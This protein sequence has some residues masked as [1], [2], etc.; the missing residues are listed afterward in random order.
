MNLLEAATRI[1][2]NLGSPDAPTVGVIQYYLRHNI[3][4][5]NNLINTGFSIEPVDGTIEP[6]LDEDAFGVYQCLYLIYYYG[7]KARENL[8]A[9]AID[10][11][12]EVAENGAVVRLT[13]RNSI[14]LSYIQLKKQEEEQLHKL[15]HFYR[16]NRATPDAVHGE[17]DDD[18]E[19]DGTSSVR[20]DEND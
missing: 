10:P 11:V 8:G 20:D 12:L 9:A 7:Q 16:M 3:G 19:F 1:H 2:Q 17:D 4:Q 5:L 18:V 14:S 13:S 15:V 6:D